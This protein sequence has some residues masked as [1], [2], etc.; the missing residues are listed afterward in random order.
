MTR[1][2]G[3]ECP[4]CG[5]NGVPIDRS[6]PVELQICDGCQRVELQVV[7]PEEPDERV[8]QLMRILVKFLADDWHRRWH[9][10][11]FAKAIMG[12]SLL[13]ALREAGCAEERIRDVLYA[14]TS[15]G[16][17]NAFI[18]RQQAASNRGKI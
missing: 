18:D 9:G 11:E 1:P 15:E 7:P 5:D 4:W 12:N 14:N 13:G 8:E 10:A 2:E 17:L 6:L 3:W 16:K